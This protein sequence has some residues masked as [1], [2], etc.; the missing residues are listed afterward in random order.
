MMKAFYTILI[1]LI[2]FVGFGQCI[3][4]NCENGQ[5]TM[6]WYNGSKY[7]GEWKNGNQN[8]QGTLTYGKGEWEGNK[9]VSEVENIK[10]IFE[11]SLEEIKESDDSIEDYSQV[12]M[13]ALYCNEEFV[14]EGTTF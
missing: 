2:P 5:G 1:L 13:S 3:S 12:Y 9:Y 14:W 10:N 8:G 7:V 6:T 11:E 4:G